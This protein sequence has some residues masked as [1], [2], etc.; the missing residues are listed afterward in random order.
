MNST[1]I[2][3]LTKNLIHS[4]IETMTPEY[5]SVDV[6]NSDI[7]MFIRPACRDRLAY[8]LKRPA[9][10]YQADCGEHT[11]MI[12]LSSD[13]DRRN[14]ED[15]LDWELSNEVLGADRDGYWHTWMVIPENRR[16][17]DPLPQ[18]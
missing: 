13:S 8:L 9:S 14:I 6:V 12:H 1:R 18:R 2:K 11:H 3:D 10:E 15:E 16:L 17:F 5:Y 7:S 4:L